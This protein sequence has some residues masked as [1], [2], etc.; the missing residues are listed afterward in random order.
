MG[1]VRPG[2]HLGMLLVSLSIVV[3]TRR[4]TDLF[5]FWCAKGRS[6]ICNARYPPSGSRHG[7]IP[8]AKLGRLAWLGSWMLAVVFA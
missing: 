2:W 1:G 8:C 5:A 7:G 3:S 4:R 6:A